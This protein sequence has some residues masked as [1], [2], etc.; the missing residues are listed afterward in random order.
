M[1]RRDGGKS[2]MELILAWKKR[3]FIDKMLDDG[4]SPNKVQKWML[5][6]GLEI[7]VPTVYTYAKKRK[8]AIINGVKFE[9]IADKRTA[10]SKKEM[11]EGEA[12]QSSV[13]KKVIEERKK[14][15]ELPPEEKK[16][17]QKTIKRVQSELEI[18]DAIIDKGYQTLQ[19]MEVIS[20]DMAIKAIK[21]K[22]EI[23]DG[24]HNGI[25][26]YGLEQIRLRE[27]ARENAML[28]ILL[29]FVPDEK[30]EEVLAKM[31]RATRE[32]YADL[33]LEEAYI[34]EL[35]REFEEGNTDEEASV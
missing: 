3:P 33:G 12:K 31:E 13:R 24:Q 18:L 5:E 28:M 20:P 9:A 6:N 21:L 10:K 26:M 19:M 7:S 23:T 34:M 4:E 29:E 11:G 17:L 27:A 8:E 22:N 2:K 16:Q 25:T 30:H 1:A 35:E 15:E 32:Y 14:K